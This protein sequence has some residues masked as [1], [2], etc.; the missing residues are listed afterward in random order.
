MNEQ[1]RQ[2]STCSHLIYDRVL[3]QTEDTQDSLDTYPFSERKGLDTSPFSERKGLVKHKHAF[4]LKA[5][6]PGLT[7]QIAVPPSCDK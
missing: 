4:S 2:D 6:N 7:N 3:Y 1:Q 5:R